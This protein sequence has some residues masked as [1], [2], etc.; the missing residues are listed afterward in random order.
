MATHARL[1]L[2]LTVG[3]VMAFCIPYFLIQRFPVRPPRTLHPSGLDGLVPFQPAWTAVYQSLYL[4]MPGVAWLADSAESLLRY[5]RGFV[6]LSAAGFA[7]FMAFPVV[8][9]RPLVASPEGLYGLLVRYDSPLNCFPSLH[10][11]LAAYSLLFAQHLLTG[12]RRVVAGLVWPSAAWTAAIAYSTLATKQH[13]AVDLPAG[14][15]LA[16]LAHRWAF[17]HP[18]PS[19]K[20]GRMKSIAGLG[21]LAL[22]VSVGPSAV[23]DE[24]ADHEALR[25]LRRV[26]EQAVAEDRVDLLAPHLDPEFSGV[27]LTG[28]LVVGYEGMKAYWKKLKDL[29]GPGG[30]YTVTLE[31]DLSTLFGDVALA[32]GTTNDVVVTDRGDY[33]FKSQWTAVCRRVGGEWKIL[34]VQ[35]SM[36]PVGN[37]FVKKLVSTS[38]IWSGGGGVGLGQAAGLLGGIAIGRRRKASS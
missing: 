19:L 8:G 17:A 29:M 9:P 22:A 15:L 3:L 31:P 30:K 12:A 13:Y 27:M 26:Y 21:L 33:R 1:K 14:L 24:E 25:K 6:A 28:E 32:K 18:H 36:D 5:A 4:L 10:V 2:G 35:G 20:G 11:A 34:R 16:L 23:A 7:V 38:S 37:P